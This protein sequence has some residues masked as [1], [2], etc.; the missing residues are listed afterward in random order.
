MIQVEGDPVRNPFEG[1]PGGFG[2]E[3]TQR[4][5]TLP[6]FLVNPEQAGSQET[7][8]QED[9]VPMTLDGPKISELVVLTAEV[10][11]GIPEKSLDL[12]PFAVCFDD[13]GPFPRDLVGGEVRREPGKILIVIADQ[14]S[15][16][17][18]SF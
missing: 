13:S 17:T 4:G 16:L 3:F 18:D 1:F 14:D 12:P 8:R 15:D 2:N 10:L 9:Q 11:P 6:R 7:V 5:G